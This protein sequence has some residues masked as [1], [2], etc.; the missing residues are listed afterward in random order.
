MKGEGT[1]TKDPSGGLLLMN[2][3]L[4][5]EYKKKTSLGL[6]FGGREGSLSGESPRHGPTVGILCPPGENHERGELRSGEVRGVS[7]VDDLVEEGPGVFP[8]K[9]LKSVVPRPS[10]S[11]MCLTAR[12]RRS[13]GSVGENYYH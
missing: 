10:C 5:I 3:G 4:C 2:V 8:R 11:S 6:F 12:Q 1:T 9:R 7:N 13:T